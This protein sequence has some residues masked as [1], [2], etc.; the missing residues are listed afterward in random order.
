MLYLPFGKL[1]I[2]LQSS[3]SSEITPHNTKVKNPLPIA[4]PSDN[5]SIS[6]LFKLRTEV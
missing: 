2:N 4:E 6:V 1:I 5:L 3:E